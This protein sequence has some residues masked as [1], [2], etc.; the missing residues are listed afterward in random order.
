[1]IVTVLPALAEPTRLVAMRRLAEGSEHWLCGP[2]LR[3]TRSRMSRHMQILKQA[4][5]VV[6][7]G[8]ARWVRDRT[9]PGLAP[10][11]ARLVA[12]VR[13]PGLRTPEL[14]APKLVTPERVAEEAA[15]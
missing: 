8:D 15:A 7:R 3:L 9:D 11:V 13:A 14:G 6:V 2:A 1:M 12:D 4:G 5:L 10:P